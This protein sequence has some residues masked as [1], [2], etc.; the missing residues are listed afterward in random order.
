MNRSFRL[1]LLDLDGTLY[2]GDEVVSGAPQ[3]VERLRNHGI[4]PVYFTNNSTRTPAAVTEHLR[5][6]GFRCDPA[7]VCTAAQ[8][9]AHLISCS[10]PGASTVLYLGMEG[11]RG[12]LEA[13]GLHAVRAG[14][15]H[16]VVPA[17]AV[18]GLCTDLTYRDMVDFCRAVAD[19]SHFYLTNG[20]LKLPVRDG[21][22]PGNGALGALVTATTGVKPIVAGKPE[23]SFINFALQRYGGER[24]TTVVIGDN[25]LTDI[26]V[27][28]NAGIYTIQVLS[29]VSYGG[30]DKSTEAENLSSKIAPD[31]YASSVDAIESLFQ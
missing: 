14:E 22:W 8:A 18:L 13:A 15:A 6:L 10:V 3:F 27:G 25:V 26:A 24:E 4:R 2:R 12:A 23:V 20:D 19:L 31:E 29:G 9:A 11:V 7:D 5:N 21:F 17:A 28:R 30:G 1:A 16:N